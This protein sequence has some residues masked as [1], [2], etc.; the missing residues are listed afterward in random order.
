MP[1][2]PFSP[3]M[4]TAQLYSLDLCLTGA[5]AITVIFLPAQCAA[6]ALIPSS[7]FSARISWPKRSPQVYPV[8]HS[9]G[10]TARDTS[11]E[12]ARSIIPHIASTLACMSAILTAG[13]AAAVLTKP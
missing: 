7:A 3:E 5:P 8:T 4:T 2:I 13:T 6:M 10:N 11:F 9:S 1:H 12:Q